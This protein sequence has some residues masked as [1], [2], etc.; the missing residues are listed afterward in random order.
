MIQF[1][2]F[3]FSDNETNFSRLS[4]DAT[5]DNMARDF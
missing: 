2:M 5:S 1:R 3:H 4:C